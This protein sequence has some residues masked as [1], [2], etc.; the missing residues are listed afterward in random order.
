MGALVSE[1]SEASKE[2]SSGIEQVNI[3]ITE[4]DKIV[5]QNAANAEESASGSEEMSAQAEQLKDYVSE[6]IILIQGTKEVQATSSSLKKART[7]VTRSVTPHS[8]QSANKRRMPG[9]QPKEITPD[10]LIPFDDD[11]SF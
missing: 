9:G 8:N 6:L 10:Q 1:I 5:Q 7:T 2:Q 11:D 4:M 3:A